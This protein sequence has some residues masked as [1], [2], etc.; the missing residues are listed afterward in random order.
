MV[1]VNLEEHVI[2][3][4]FSLTIFIA[5]LPDS[6]QWPQNYNFICQINLNSKDIQDT[7][8]GNFFFSGKKGILFFFLYF[9]NGVGQHSKV[10][11]Y[12]TEDV[13]HLK[14]TK[15]PSKIEEFY[16]GE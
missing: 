6:I 11:F 15:Y 2:N 3:S 8:V 4:N 12:E 16:F 7:I 14:R 5:D 1:Q 10:Y 9:E 13:K